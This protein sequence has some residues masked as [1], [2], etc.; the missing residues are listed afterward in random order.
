[1]GKRRQAPAPTEPPSVPLPPQIY[2]ATLGTGG[3]VIKGAQITQDQAETLRKSGQDV[4]VCGPNLAMNRALAKPIE[5][6][7][8]GSWKPCPPHRNLGPYVLPHCQPDPR[9]PEGHTFYET[10]SR[11]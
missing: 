11:K 2:E 6:N 1:M 4:V 7:A 10:P 3:R 8:N 5:Q 9:T